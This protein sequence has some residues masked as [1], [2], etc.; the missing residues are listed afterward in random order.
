M[1]AASPCPFHINQTRE[2]EAWEASSGMDMLAKPARTLSFFSCNTVQ[3][4]VAWKMAGSLLPSP[5]E[6]FNDPM[7]EHRR[8]LLVNQQYSLAAAGS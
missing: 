3:A 5:L 2:V 1:S 4:S 7:N 8:F 6:R